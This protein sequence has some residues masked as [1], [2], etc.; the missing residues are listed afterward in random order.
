MKHILFILL[1]ACLQLP[2]Q[3]TVTILCTV[4]DMATFDLGAPSA[5]WG[6]TCLFN[7]PN[8]DAFYAAGKGAKHYFTNEKC[9]PARE[10][11]HNPT[12]P[13]EVGR[14]GTNI[15][16]DGDIRAFAR[17]GLSLAENCNKNGDVC[18]ILGKW[19]GG[20]YNGTPY[21]Y[22]NYSLTLDG[23]SWTLFDSDDETEMR[24]WRWNGRKW[25]VPNRSTKTIIRKTAAFTNTGVGSPERVRTRS[26][27]ENREITLTD[28]VLMLLDIA[29]TDTRNWFVEIN[30]TTGH[31]P[32]ECELADYYQALDDLYGLGANPA[33]T[34]NYTDPQRML[35][36]RKV[37]QELWDV[38][39]GR[40]TAKIQELSTAGLNV[41]FLFCSDNPAPTQYQDQNLPLT[42]YKGFIGSSTQVP[43]MAWSNNLFSGGTAYPHLLTINDIYHTIV[44]MMGWTPQPGEGKSMVAALAANSQLHADMDAQDLCLGLVSVEGVVAQDGSDIL[45]H[46]TSD[47][48]TNASTPADNNQ[49]YEV[50]TDPTEITNIF[51]SAQGTNLNNQ[52]NAKSAMQPTQ[53]GNVGTPAWFIRMPYTGQYPD[54]YVIP[55]N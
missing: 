29:K 43:F 15:V 53:E 47:Y 5:A 40:L 10:N 14:A 45:L 39:F 36:I 9:G 13:H 23:G 31:S 49:V 6:E 54:D 48:S 24:D 26:Y 7:T 46:R 41:N 25:Q 11:W 33:D 20:H 22:Y 55:N 28:S 21:S 32:F 19:H 12:A 4:D 30:Y 1:C 2:A 51:S 50:A 44:E 16:E 38:Q 52:L 42:L 34:V 18:A 3:T 17:Q 37:Q 8:F 35:A 27:A